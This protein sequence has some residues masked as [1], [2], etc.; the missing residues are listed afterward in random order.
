MGGQWPVYS[1]LAISCTNALYFPGTDTVDIAV[2]I[3]RGAAR[4]QA[5][6]VA[7]HS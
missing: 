2:S 4:L 5:A 6:S 1:A 7:V 3:G